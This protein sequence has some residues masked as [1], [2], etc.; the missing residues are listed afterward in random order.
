MKLSSQ[1]HIIPG[2]SFLDRLKYLRGCGVPGVEL[3]LGDRGVM[4]GTL[5]HRVDEILNGCTSTGVAP[6]I[7]TT[8][9]F[10]LLDADP[11]KRQ[12]AMNEVRDA[13][14]VAARVGALGVCVVPR[15]GPPSL[16]DLS[17]LA[18]A[19]ELEHQ[20]FVREMKELAEQAER[21]GVFIVLE[22]LHRYL[23]KFLRTVGH[24]KQICE[25]VRSPALKILVDNFQIYNEEVTVEGAIRL[26]GALVGHVHISDNNRRLPP[27][28]STDFV[29]II[30]ALN[31]IGYNGFLSFECD[32]AGAPLEPQFRE[33][34]QCMQSLL[35]KAGVGL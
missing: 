15:F 6:S 12:S 35:A 24:A 16:P 10:D 3:T 31:D 8:K 5:R 2:D 22:P 28:G 17:P 33:A 7:I 30:S 21:L 1:E 13:L 14:D 19:W 20:L 11:G 26:G 25:D 4:L 29:P 32:T 23:V 18:T 34:T 9:V 27:Q